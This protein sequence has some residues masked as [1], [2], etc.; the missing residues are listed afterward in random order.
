MVHDDGGIIPI[1]V[2]QADSCFL[3]EKC[4]GNFKKGRQG[5]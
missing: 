3:W 5:S 1:R 2:K 4:Q